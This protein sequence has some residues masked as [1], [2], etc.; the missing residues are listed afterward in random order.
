MKSFVLAFIA[1]LICTA[2]FFLLDALSLCF[3]APAIIWSSIYCRRFLLPSILISGLFLDLFTWSTPLGFHLLANVLSVAFVEK[4][5]RKL[6]YNIWT[7]GWRLWT[8]SLAYTFV[9]LL[10]LLF[11]RQMPTISSKGLIGWI[12][13]DIL[14]MP[15]IDVFYGLIVY[16]ALILIK[17]CL[18]PS[19]RKADLS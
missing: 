7:F 12:F 3:F 18:V 17:S 6:Q 10:I 2:L 14:I 8:F 19:P 9:Q 1:L 11:L 13:T 15:L 4:I 16:I 5:S